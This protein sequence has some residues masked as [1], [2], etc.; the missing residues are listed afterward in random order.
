M[1]SNGVDSNGTDDGDDWEYE[2]DEAETEV[3]MAL[4]A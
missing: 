4:R 3:S 2:Y 1:A